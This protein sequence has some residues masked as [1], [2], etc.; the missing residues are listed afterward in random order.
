MTSSML[1][2]IVHESHLRYGIT[3]QHRLSM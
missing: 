2:V 1:H 3:D